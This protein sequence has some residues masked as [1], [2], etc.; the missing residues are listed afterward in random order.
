MTDHATKIRRMFPPCPSD[1]TGIG[2]VTADRLLARI[3]DVLMDHLSSA[4]LRLVARALLASYQDGRAARAE[5]G[6]D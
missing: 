2:P 5:G 4:D 6:C 1:G 3:P